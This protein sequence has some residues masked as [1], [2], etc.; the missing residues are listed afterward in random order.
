MKRRIEKPWSDVLFLIGITIAVYL[1]MKYL[2][3]LVFPFLLAILFAFLLHPIVEKLNHK[4]KLPR[5]IL[6][7][8]VVSLFVVLVGIPFILLGWKLIQESCNLIRSYR[9][10]KGEV[11][12]IWCL[13][14]DRLEEISGIDT[15][16]VLNWGGGQAN[17]IMVRLQEKVVPFLMNCSVD[18]MKG[19]AGFFWKFIVTVV[20]TVLT[21]TDYPKLQ[22]RFLTTAPGRLAGRL[23]KSTMNAGGTYLKAQLIIWACVSAVCVA[24]L[25]L[26]GNRYALLAGIGIGFCDALP[27]LG[28]GTIFVPWLIIKLLQKEYLFA[29]LY[30]ALYIICNLIREFLEPKLV[31][32]GLGIHPLAVIFSLY[33]GICIYGGAGIVLGPL[34]ILLIWE[35]YQ[36]WKEG[37]AKK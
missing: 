3:A 36:V 11:E 20:A 10:W 34:S 37:I 32:K 14:C 27:F 30:G 13:C 33:V 8:L 19:I 12:R 4:L 18:G 23:G 5:N 22:E 17:S 31:G 16:T 28:T 2:L 15:A 24:G 25:F 7:F 6:S 1:G 21:L 9:G 26:S 29:V 35:L